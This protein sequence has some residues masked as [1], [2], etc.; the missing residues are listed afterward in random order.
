M[1]MFSVIDEYWMR[2]A[3][4]LAE[5]A[6]LEGE[7]P[8]AAVLVCNDALVSASAN[9]PITL[10]DPTAHAEM[11]VLREAATKLG[12]YRLLDSTLYVTLEPCM[13]CAGAMVHAR[14]KRLVYG[15]FDKKAG[16]VSSCATLLDATFINH[17]V[18]YQGG[19]FAPECGELL[20]KFFAARR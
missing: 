3:L 5:K 15:A 14:I 8:V 13:M 1:T 9:R 6:A 4:S 16:A 7:V 11:L 2:Y 20:S 10:L 18:A 17:V 19:L 12:N